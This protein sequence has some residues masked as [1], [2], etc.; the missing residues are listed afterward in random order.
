MNFPLPSASLGRVISSLGVELLVTWGCG[1]AWGIGAT[2]FA[3]SILYQFYGP[4]GLSDARHFVRVSWDWGVVLLLIA[5]ALL[6]GYL[7]RQRRGWLSGLITLPVSLSTPF[8]A[9]IVMVAAYALFWSP[10]WRLFDYTWLVRIVDWGPFLVAQGITALGVMVLILRRNT[11]SFP[12]RRRGLGYGAMVGAV[13]S[14]ASCLSLIVLQDH[15]LLF[16]TQPPYWDQYLWLSF[17]L[18]SALFYFL[19]Q[20]PALIWVSTVYVLEITRQPAGWLGLVLWLVLV[21]ATFGMPFIFDWLWVISFF[22][23]GGG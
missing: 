4:R 22:L 23:L 3:S 15:L 14:L 10:W 17:Y 12:R 19:W 2:A 11:P 18:R 5:P 13:L 8:I 9:N 20:M 1:L 6:G 16:L 21:L 7:A